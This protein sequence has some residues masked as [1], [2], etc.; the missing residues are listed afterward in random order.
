MLLRRVVRKRMNTIL[1]NVA[2]INVETM[3]LCKQMVLVANALSISP[4]TRVP[5]H[6]PPLSADPEKSSY[7]MVLAS[8]ANLIQ[9]LTPQPESA[10]LTHVD[11]G[12]S[13]PPQVNVSLA[14]ATKFRTLAIISAAILL[15]AMQANSSQPPENALTVAL[16]QSLGPKGDLV[17]LLHVRRERLYSRM[18]LARNA[19]STRKYQMTRRPVCLLHARIK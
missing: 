3:K 5:V 2:L 11:Q 4:L 14:M 6:V 17:S 18:G 9:D 10:F 19:I 1:Q 7:P 13:W 16:S 15:L 8:N 12:R